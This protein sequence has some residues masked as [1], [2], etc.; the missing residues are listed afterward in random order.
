MESRQCEEPP[1]RHCE[2]GCDPESMDPCGEAGSRCLKLQDEDGND[3]GSFCFEAC[4][5]EPNECPKG[6]S[7]QELKDENDMVLNRLCFRDCTFN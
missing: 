4:G 3:L 6:Y 7:C 1:G 5:Q 2:M